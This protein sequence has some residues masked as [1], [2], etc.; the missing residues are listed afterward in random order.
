MNNLE[1]PTAVYIYVS[2]DMYSPQLEGSRLYGTLNEFSLEPFSLMTW[3]IIDRKEDIFEL[4]NMR[5][6]DKIVSALWGG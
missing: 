3:Y 6:Q 4:D 1:C 2:K 5:D